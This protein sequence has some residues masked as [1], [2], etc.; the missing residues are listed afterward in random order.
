LRIL[1]FDTATSATVVAL[2][3]SDA[4]TT[5]ERRDDPP[6]GERPRHTTRLMSFI[7]DVLG[8]AGVSFTELDRIA[9]GV[10]PGTFTGLRIGVATARALA[11]ASGLE[12][13]GVSTLES[14]ALN[15]AGRDDADAVC[16]VLDARRREVFAAAWTLDGHE[17]LLDGSALAPAALVPH[18]SSST[19]AI[20]D[21]AIA[22]RD[23]LERSGALIPGDESD[24]HKVTA[25]NHCRLGLLA[26]ASGA[27]GVLPNYLRLPDAELARRS[28]T[29]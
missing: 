29:N 26:H 15:A 7:A 23:V 25:V 10:G 28:S 24:L 2:V 14:L 20:G 8:E 1:G 17:P 19:L 18:L 27:D 21:G 11:Q 9:V 3:D 12:T 13:V 5:F 16:A 22:F 4:A 6:R